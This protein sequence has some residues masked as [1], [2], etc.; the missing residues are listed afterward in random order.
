MTVSPLVQ[1]IR[2]FDS[3]ERGLLLAWA[4]GGPLRLSEEK[5]SLIGATIDRRL[6]AEAFVAMDYTLDWLYA[7]TQWYLHPEVA[8]PL[9][10]TPWP[11]GDALT[12]SPEDVDLLIAWEDHGRPHLILLEAKGFTGWRNA[13]MLHKARRLDVIFDGDLADRFDVHFLLV[14]PAA[15]AGL[16]MTGWP[17]WMTPGRRVRFVEMPDPGSRFA[18]QRCNEVGHGTRQNPTH[19]QATVRTRIKTPSHAG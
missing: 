6:P 15:S 5:R 17:E 2:A 19:W 7:A 8:K 10:P 4:V 14:G 9:Q 12:A 1:K 16:D 3:H 13:Q 18:V 11:D